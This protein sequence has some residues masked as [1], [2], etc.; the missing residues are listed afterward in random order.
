MARTAVMGGQRISKVLPPP[1]SLGWARCDAAAVPLAD[2]DGSAVEDGEAA[3]TA[4]CDDDG[5]GRGEFPAPRDGSSTR[6]PR[7]SPGAHAP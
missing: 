6:T 7:T 4:S 1:S 5:A 3:T 2:G